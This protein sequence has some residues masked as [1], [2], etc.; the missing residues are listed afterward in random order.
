MSAIGDLLKKQPRAKTV[1]VFARSGAMYEDVRVVL[2]ASDSIVTLERTGR[3]EGKT[4]YLSLDEVAGFS[5][6]RT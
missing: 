6:S 3:F 4:L 5:V 1:T 2:T